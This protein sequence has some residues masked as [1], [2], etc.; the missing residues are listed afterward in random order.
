MGAVKSEFAKFGKTIESA[1]KTA[2]TL[3]N[4]LSLEGEVQVRL[5]AMDKILKKIEA[6]DAPSLDLTDLLE[7]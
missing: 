2:N 1:H 7:E 5:R 4:K 3:T 6:L